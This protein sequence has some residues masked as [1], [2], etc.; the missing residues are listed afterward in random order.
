MKRVC[1]ASVKSLAYSF[2]K[3][4]L[5]ALRKTDSRTRY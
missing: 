5:E 4:F 1:F 2:T 3:G